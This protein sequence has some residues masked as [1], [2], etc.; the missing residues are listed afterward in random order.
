MVGLI[1]KIGCGNMVR[2]AAMREAINIGLIGNIRRAHPVIQGPK[3]WGEIRL[4]RDD[5]FK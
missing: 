4:K 2:V 5:Y 3:R 1:A